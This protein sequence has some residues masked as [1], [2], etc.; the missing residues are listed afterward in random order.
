[1]SR[2]LELRL[3]RICY[4]IALPFARLGDH[5]DGAERRRWA[6]ENAAQ[7]QTVVD[8]PYNYWLNHQPGR[9]LAKFPPEKRIISFAQQREWNVLDGQLMAEARALWKDGPPCV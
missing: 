5:F 2:S 3:A 9:T 1:M 6:I 8:A 7:W 4:G